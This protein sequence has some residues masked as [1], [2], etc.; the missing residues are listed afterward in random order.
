MQLCQ[1]LD[2]R[3]KLILD[4]ISE[5]PMCTRMD[6]SL[7]TGIPYSTVRYRLKKYVLHGWINQEKYR[8][9]YRYSLRRS[10]RMVV[11][12]FQFT[13]EV[14]NKVRGE[15]YPVERERHIEVIVEVDKPDMIDIEPEYVLAVFLDYSAWAFSIG[16]QRGRRAKPDKTEWPA[17]DFWLGEFIKRE[18][19]RIL[20]RMKERLPDARIAVGSTDVMPSRYM[21]GEYF[22]RITYTDYDYEN[23]S[24]TEEKNFEKAFHEFKECRFKHELVGWIIDVDNRNF[25][26]GTPAYFKKKYGEGRLKV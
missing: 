26:W 7:G 8:R 12:S 11:T 14:A 16:T 4:F 10:R 24:F 21:H 15:E 22:V 9:A 19:N 1:E 23:N 2:E 17:R 20:K 5:N 6:I 13:R 3:D 18:Q 25:A